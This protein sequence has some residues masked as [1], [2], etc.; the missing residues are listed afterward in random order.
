[1]NAQNSWKPI[2]IGGLVAALVI[3]GFILGRMDAFHSEGPAQR[4][5][6]KVDQAAKQMKQSVDQLQQDAGKSGG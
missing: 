2:L 5:G 3:G 4:L 6:Q 1:M